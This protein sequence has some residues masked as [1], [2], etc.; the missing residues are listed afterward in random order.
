M[1][2]IPGEWIDH[3]VSVSISGSNGR[4][5]VCYPIQS[6]TGAAPDFTVREEALDYAAAIARAIRFQ[7]EVAHGAALQMDAKRE[8]EPKT[9]TLD[10]V[11]RDSTAAGWVL[12]APGLYILADWIKRGRPFRDSQRRTRAYIE[13]NYGTITVEHSIEIKGEPA[14][15]PYSPEVSGGA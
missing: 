14:T 3:G 11:L 4:Y 9:I 8:P 15:A 5:E 6:G 10:L 12:V 7:R 2:P 1:Q 13:E